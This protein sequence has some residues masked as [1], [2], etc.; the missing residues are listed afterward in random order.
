MKIL[1]NVLFITILSFL[2][3]CTVNAQS[4]DYKK[5]YTDY[6]KTYNVD[7]IYPESVLFYDLNSDNIPEMILQKIETIEDEMNTN[8]NTICYV[9]TVKNNKLQK[10]HTIQNKIDTTHIDHSTKLDTIVFFTTSNDNNLY[11]G[12]QDFN[13]SYN[14]TYYK[15]N[16]DNTKV[17]TNLIG[18]TETKF[19]SNYSTHPLNTNSDKYYYGNSEISKHLF[20][21]T[22]NFKQSLNFVSLKNIDKVIKSLD[23]YNNLP[24]NP[25]YKFG[26][27]I[28]GIENVMGNLYC[29][30]IA[31]NNGLYDYFEGDMY[32]LMINGNVI[33]K[34]NV[35]VEN[36]KIYLPLR[37]IC[38]YI[39]KEII[40][41]N[42]INSVS[43]NNT[44]I[45]LNNY[46]KFNAKNVNGITYLPS[47][48]FDKYLNFNIYT[49]KIY[50]GKT[51]GNMEGFKPVD[52]S[53]NAINLEDKSLKLNYAP[54][55]P[56]KDEI[57]KLIFKDIHTTRVVSVEEP[58]I[59]GRYYV[60][61]AKQ[62]VDNTNIEYFVYY[63]Y[64]NYSDIKYW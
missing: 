46:I 35:I 50:E 43:I 62:K 5:I 18:K 41:N 57:S 15:L 55:L 22:L 32:L 44:N 7:K 63:L 29:N 4:I 37:T 11:Y 47:E 39:S 40:Y 64:D 25:T 24:A 26:L 60:F 8:F 17:T 45:S 23:N 1:K 10:I 27:R 14:M 6:L 61:K 20:L 53:I 54:T 34:A 31:Y 12:L 59:L 30:Y 28:Y 16:Y 9:Y 19:F 21:D 48:F 52:F 38:N 3:I 42:K 51:S 49:Q 13:I 58:T 36:N 2:I 56:L 33:P